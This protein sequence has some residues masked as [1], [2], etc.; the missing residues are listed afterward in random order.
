MA[1][2]T[3]PTSSNFNFPV[4]LEPLMIDGQPSGFFGTVRRDE[5]VPRVFAA[6]SE[7]YGLIQNSEFINQI[8]DGMAKA[9][10]SGFERSVAVLDHGARCQASWTFRNRTVKVRKVGDEVAFKITA[11]NSYDGLW[12]LSLID[13]IERLVCTNGAVRSEKGLNLTSKHTPNLNLTRIVNGLDTMLSRFEDWA[14]DLDLLVLPVGQA[15]GS[16]I[17]SHAQEEG[18]ISGSTREGILGFWNAPRR[19]ED[20]DRTLYNLWNASTEYLTHVVR[21]ERFQYAD[22]VNAELT[23]WMMG[24]SRDS[25]RFERVRKPVELVL[26]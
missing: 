7:R 5:G 25:H 15:E 23:N 24:L 11:R 17:L 4:S 26:N 19:R 3:V 14:K 1:R 16:H 21:R 18:I 12:K 6:T 13:T 10:L 20:E 8:E 2:P 9:G 22:T